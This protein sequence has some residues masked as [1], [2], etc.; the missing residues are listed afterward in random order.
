M[1]PSRRYRRKQI[2]VP[3]RRH[4]HFTAM[5]PSR[6]QHRNEITVPSRLH[7]EIYVMIKSV[8]CVLFAHAAY[9][10]QHESSIRRTFAKMQPARKI[11]VKPTEHHR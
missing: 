4:F 8:I 6:R 9:N 1:V 3:S 10:F 2:A 5:G 11:H 7:L